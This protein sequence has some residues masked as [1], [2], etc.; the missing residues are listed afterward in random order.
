[1]SVTGY[2]KSALAVELTWFAEQLAGECQS[3]LL[4]AAGKRP[5]IEIKPDASFVTET[6]RAIETR[7]RDL[8]E[9]TYPSTES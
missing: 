1:M 8:I 5:K 9:Q 4:G 3:M 2:T 7:L 6:D